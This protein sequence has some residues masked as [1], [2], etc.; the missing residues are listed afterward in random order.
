[1]PLIGAEAVAASVLA[2]LASAIISAYLADWVGLAIAPFVILTI[3]LA[4]AAA[5]FVMLGR[6]A[7]RDRRRSRR[8]LCL[9]LRH[10][11]VAAVA[12]AA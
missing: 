3:S 12:G 4:V 5:T 1:M 7:A 6:Q 8:L 10:V 9:R 2:L 11:R